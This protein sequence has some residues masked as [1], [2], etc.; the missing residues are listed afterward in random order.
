TYQCPFL[1][2]WPKVAAFGQ[3]FKYQTNEFRFSSRYISE[4]IL[5]STQESVLHSIGRYNEYYPRQ[6]TPISQKV[7][8]CAA[9]VPT[10]ALETK[11]GGRY[12]YRMKSADRSAALLES[13]NGQETYM[14][15]SVVGRYGEMQIKANPQKDE[16]VPLLVMTWSLFLLNQHF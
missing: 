7:L 6:S 12:L 5:I 13:L 9:H 3:E 8:Y 11:W 4:L 15:L 16:I 10:M 2:A 1:P 14:S